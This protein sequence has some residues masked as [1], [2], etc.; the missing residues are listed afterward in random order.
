M[1][2]G[3]DVVVLV[4]FGPIARDRGGRL[5]LVFFEHCCKHALEDQSTVYHETG[6]IHGTHLSA[7]NSTS[8]TTIRID[9][10][11]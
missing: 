7:I 5:R 4:I 2:L 8:R 10:G 11:R 3:G 1:V 6:S 9:N